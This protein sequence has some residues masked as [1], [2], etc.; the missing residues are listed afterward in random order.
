M[1]RIGRIGR[2]ADEAPAP[3]AVRHPLLDDLE[4][5]GI[6]TA[7]SRRHAE[8]LA[9]QTGEPIDQV[10]TKLGLISERALAETLGRIFDLSSEPDFQAPREP[11]F[12]SDLNVG[13]LEARRLMPVRDAGDHVEIATIDPGDTDGLRGLQVAIGRPV[14][15][16]VTTP[17]QFT[18][19]FGRL[20]RRGE[21]ATSE[22]DELGL[23]VSADADR[24]KDLASEEPVVR[25]VNRLIAEAARAR[26]SD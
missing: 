22:V 3:P 2:D 9:A 19:V 5:N 26:A 15:P 24:L 11:L 12:L 1:W 13:F 23:D 20:Y 18:S 14:R 10:L 21:E 16:F 17:S 6:L 7:S 8:E 25:L 4:K